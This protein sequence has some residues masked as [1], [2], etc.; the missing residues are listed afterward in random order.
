[1]LKYTSKY[2]KLQLNLWR[3]NTIS[4]QQ[5]VEFSLIRILNSKHLN[6]GNHAQYLNL[7]S[8]SISNAFYLKTGKRIHKEMQFAL[9]VI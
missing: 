3:V 2:S 7:D 4:D 6:C 9:K 8:S 5:S 1:M